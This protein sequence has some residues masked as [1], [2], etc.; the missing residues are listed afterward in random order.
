MIVWGLVSMGFMFLKGTT[1]FY[2]MRFLL[3]VAEAGFFPGIVYYL[4][5]WFPPLQRA[6]AISRFMIA[7]PL[8]AAI[9]NP[10]GAWLLQLDGRLGMAGWQWVVLL[11]GVP[12]VLLGISVLRFLPDGPRDARWLRPDER[13]WLLARLERERE[14]SPARA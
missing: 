12:T 5:Q 13:A 2:A 14:A 8:S 9:G 10:V 7:L 11:E 1:M 3:G 4:S 6:R